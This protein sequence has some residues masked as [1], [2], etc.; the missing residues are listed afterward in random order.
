MI[1]PIQLDEL[2]EFVEVSLVSRANQAVARIRYNCKLQDPHA[3]VDLSFSQDDLGGM[4]FRHAGGHCRWAYRARV[5]RD[6]TDRV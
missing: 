6:G 4:V 1:G 5:L 3:P 2:E